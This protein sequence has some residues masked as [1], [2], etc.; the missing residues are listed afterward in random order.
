M[1]MQQKKTKKTQN[2]CIDE[3]HKS[4][5]AGLWLEIMLGS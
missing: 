4:K 3:G 1:D 5:N 2:V